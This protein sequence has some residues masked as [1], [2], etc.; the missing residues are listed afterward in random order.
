MSEEQAKK[1]Q[2]E[3]EGEVEAK[4]KGKGKPGELAIA[5][6]VSIT[7]GA[8]LMEELDEKP[9][10]PL[11]IPSLEGPPEPKETFEEAS[12]RA[13]PLKPRLS[14]AERGSRLFFLF[15]AILAMGQMLLIMVF[16]FTESVGLVF[17]QGGSPG[18]SLGS[19]LFGRDWYPTYPDP[20]FGAF[21]LIC[22]SL[23]VTLVS[24]A[25]AAPLG[26][27]LA[28][29][30][31]C[32]AGRRT[33][34]FVKPAVELLASVPSVVLGLVGMVVI[35]PFLQQTLNLPTGLNLLNASVILAVM[36]TPTIA[37]LGEDALSAVPQDIKDASYALGATRWETI[38]RVTTPAA[39]GG[40]STSVILGLGRSLGE[41][42]VVLMVAGGAAQIPNSLFDSIR[43][44]TSTLA[45]EMGETA[46]GSRHYQA[47]FALGVILFFMTLAFN[48]LAWY[49]SRRWRTRR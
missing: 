26:L 47:L 44:L 23:A 2:G 18:V 19:F 43:P 40:L 36:A 35:A 28:M 32:V 4:G 46:I 17:S 15:C 13:I 24:T 14:K 45:A 27:G 30:L 10:A 20:S 41:T 42:M 38:W 1:K 6:V 12:R 48:L 9:K 39:L 5:G 22:G 3:G 33:R 8:S 29:F 49:L 16:L 7:D 37:S 31:S 21:A 11:K 34:E 25:I